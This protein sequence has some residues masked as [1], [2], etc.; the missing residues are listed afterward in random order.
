MDRL[1]EAVESYVRA[2]AGDRRVGC[3][4]QTTVPANRDPARLGRED[5]VARAHRPATAR[6]LVLLGTLLCASWLT[7]MLTPVSFA[8]A[9]AT[10]SSRTRCG[11][12]PSWIAHTVLPA[13]HQGPLSV[14]FAARSNRAEALLSIQS[15][16]DYAQ[17]I[18]LSGVNVVF[19]ESSF[20]DPLEAGVSNWLW[21][22]SLGK[23]KEVLMLGPGQRALLAIG[24]PPP[25]RAPRQVG[26]QQAQPAAAALGHLA[27][28]FLSAAGGTYISP[29][30]ER[31]VMAG[32]YTTVSSARTP[33]SA[34]RGL[35][36]C[37]DGGDNNS[38]PGSKRRLRAVARGIFRLARFDVALNLIGGS[39]RSLS[40][41]AFTIRGSPPGRYNPKIRLGPANFG[42]VISGRR[43]VKHL[44]A[45]GGSPPYRYYL[46]NEAGM[47]APSWL[48]LAP[49]GTVIIEPPQGVSVT[50][51]VRVYV[52]DSTGARSQDLPAS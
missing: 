30:I 5:G 21:H 32:V 8:K 25:Q 31:C 4:A 34:L 14:C 47:R 39:D 37:V 51:R 24:R 35:R 18:T 11:P 41:V 52:V 40:R 42:T 9:T 7:A 15:H 23:T 38:H 27:W 36:A 17:L 3:A 48:H 50:V 49:D 45:T 12:H 19:Y 16:R 44:T 46:R 20:S 29:S 10:L 43:T 28:A 6:K 26:M 1:H 22:L 13:G 2:L 33:V